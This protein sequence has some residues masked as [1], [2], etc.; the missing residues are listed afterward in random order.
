MLLA[1][2]KIEAIHLGVRV[3]DYSFTVIDLFMAI[4]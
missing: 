3:T 1:A 2:P 4:R